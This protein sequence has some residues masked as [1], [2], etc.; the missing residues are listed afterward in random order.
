MCGMAAP[1]LRREDRYLACSI[2]ATISIGQP[3]LAAAAGR[4]PQSLAHQPTFAHWDPLRIG[5][6]MSGSQL[7]HKCSDM[8]CIPREAHRLNGTTRH[9]ME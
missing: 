3:G 4:Q 7:A 5:P 8:A 6:A 2:T 9:M 1:H